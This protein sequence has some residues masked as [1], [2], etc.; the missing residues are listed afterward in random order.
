VADLGDV[1]V[2]DIAI[3]GAAVGSYLVYSAFSRCP[4]WVPFAVA[5]VSVVLL[6]LTELRSEGAI[7]FVVLGLTHV[8]LNES[9]RSVVLT[10]GVV[11]L[12]VPGLLVA[13][14]EPT[15]VGSAS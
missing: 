14:G 9:R 12:A 1:S 13:L 5:C 4:V 15:G 8:G 2:G 10:C 6:K 3:I 11:G 7:F